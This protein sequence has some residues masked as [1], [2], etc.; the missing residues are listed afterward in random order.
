MIVAVA[1]EVLDEPRLTYQGHEIDL[2]PPWPRKTLRDAIREGSGV[3]YVEYPDQASL[4]AAARAAG[5][6]VASDTVVPRIVD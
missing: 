4:L 5:A 2:T 1:T 3:D 6:D